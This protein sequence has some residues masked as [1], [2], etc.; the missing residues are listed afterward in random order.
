MVETPRA[1]AGLAARGR[2]PGASRRFKQGIDLDDRRGQRREGSRG[3]TQRRRDAEL[4]LRRGQGAAGGAGGGGVQ[5]FDAG[6]A[7]ALGGGAAAPAA[8]YPPVPADPPPRVAAADADDD[9]EVEMYTPNPSMAPAER[10]EAPPLPAA[11]VAAA[12][13]PAPRLSSAAGRA[14][15]AAAGAVADLTGGAIGSVAGVVAGPFVGIAQTPGQLWRGKGAA[16]TGARAAAGAASAVT[17]AAAGGAVGSALGTLAGT[18]RGVYDVAA[19]EGTGGT[20]YEAARWGARHGTGL[21]VGGLTGGR[22]GVQQPSEMTR[23]GARFVAQSMASGVTGAGLGFICAA[24]DMP[25]EARDLRSRIEEGFAQR[26]GA[27]AQRRSAA[28]QRRV[29]AEQ[30]RV[31]ATYERVQTHM[32]NL[33]KLSQEADRKA[34]D[35]VR[36]LRGKAAAEQQRIRQQAVSLLA[37]RRELDAMRDNSCLELNN[38]ELLMERI[39]HASLQTVVAATMTDAAQTLKR[40]NAELRG[41]VGGVDELRGELAVGRALQ[42]EL[43]RPLPGAGA[44][45]EEAA[46]ELAELELAVLGGK[47]DEARVPAT[48]PTKKRRP[49][50][51]AAPREAGGPSMEAAVAHA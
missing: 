36:G 2:S 24:R 9:E 48:H 39:A 13:V 14:F 27:A 18:G 6:L 51:A 46:A 7:A 29:E 45:D 21:V 42:D 22:H 28:D 50:A 44:G 11:D 23:A 47:L 8:L 17:A 34:R 25:A 49:A 15:N 1:G 16:H 35:A 4:R 12:E 31:R 37:K 41:A 10:G 40:L 20:A 5:F 26:K 19:G 30:Q 43:A 3:A 32:M 38:L 33:D